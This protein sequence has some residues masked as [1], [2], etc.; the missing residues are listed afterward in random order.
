[1]ADQS[2]LAQPPR[3]SSRPNRAHRQTRRS[4][5]QDYSRRRNHRGIRAIASAAL[6]PPPQRSASSNSPAESQEN[7]NS[8]TAF[9]HNQGQS[10]TL[11]VLRALSVHLPTPDIRQDQRSP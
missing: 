7:H 4:P 1:M 6:D 2:P 11:A 8:S 10:R 3:S 5:E 9:S